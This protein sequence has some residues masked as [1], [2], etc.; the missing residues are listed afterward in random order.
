MLEWGYDADDEYYYSEEYLET[1]TCT[2]EELGLSG[3]ST[4]FKPIKPSSAEELRL[5][6]GTLQCIKDEDSWIKGNGQADEGRQMVLQFVRCTGESCAS[7][8]EL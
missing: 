6:L 3:S 8:Q 1:H 4:A 7:P 5:S 2:E